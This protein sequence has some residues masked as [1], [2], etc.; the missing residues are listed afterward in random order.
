MVTFE[1]DC[2]TDD[3]SLLKNPKP[4]SALT[5]VIEVTR[6][7]SANNLREFDRVRKVEEGSNLRFLYD[8]KIP[9][10]SKY[11]CPPL[12][13]VDTAT[14]IPVKYPPP[15]DAYYKNVRKEFGCGVCMPSG[16]FLSMTRTIGDV[17]FKHYGI[18]HAPEI[19]SIDLA[20]LP[21]GV[22]YCLVGITDGVDDNWLHEHIAKFVTD[23]T[24]L[25]TVSDELYFGP[26][27]FSVSATDAVDYRNGAMRVADAFLTRNERFATKNFGT[28][29]DDASVVLLYN[30]VLHS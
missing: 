22:D 10:L 19:M 13:E 18:T 23:L 6:N 7:H 20:I 4:P 29:I 12:Y 11:D 2:A 17:A 16:S 15:D 27:K 21:R 28:D 14:N 8:D 9:R 25:K 1:K 24:C 26:E 3:L 5:N 30:F